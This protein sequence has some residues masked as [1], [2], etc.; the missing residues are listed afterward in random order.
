MA[1][2]AD[3]KDAFP[4]AAAKS[5]DRRSS[6]PQAV[7]S[8]CIRLSDHICNWL[9]SYPDRSITGPCASGNL[10]FFPILA[11][12]P[13][14]RRVAPQRVPDPPPPLR[15]TAYKSSLSLTALPDQAT[16]S[17]GDLG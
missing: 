10:R 4:T 2:A 5:H 6:H 13:R 16:A 3:R 12:H 14:P 9:Q 8:A 17:A 11:M 7:G 15:I 1:R